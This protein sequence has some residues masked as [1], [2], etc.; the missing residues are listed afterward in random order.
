MKK[1][2][3]RTWCYVMRP[4]AYE[5]NCDL[6]GSN[7]LN[8]SEFEHLVWCY[9]CKKDTPGTGGIFGGPIPLELSKMLGISFDR[10]DIHSFKLLR[11]RITKTGKRYW[12]KE[13]IKA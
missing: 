13:R 4:S 3:L 8:W 10:I 7:N 11:M 9:K 6:C 12:R 1:N 2:K 5:I